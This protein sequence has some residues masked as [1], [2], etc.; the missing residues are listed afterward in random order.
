MNAI[1]M[2]KPTAVYLLSSAILI[3]LTFVVSRVGPL[4]DLSGPELQYPKLWA[5]AAIVGASAFGVL[6]AQAYA[7][8]VEKPWKTPQA[9]VQLLFSGY[10]LLGLCGLWFSL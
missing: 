3:L 10:F 2:L 8:R 6:G 4:L 1:N 5:S 7:R 9:Q